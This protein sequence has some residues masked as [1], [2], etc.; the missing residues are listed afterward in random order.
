MKQNL[1]I[2]ANRAAAR[3]EPQ[4]PS[5]RNFLIIAPAPV[6]DAS[7]YEEQV[8]A[9]AQ[10]LSQDGYTYVARS[11]QKQMED[12]PFGVRYLPLHED[13]P[14]FGHMTAVVVAGDPVWAERAAA[15]YRGADVFLLQPAPSAHVSV[16]KSPAR[17]KNPLVLPVGEA[18]Q[19]AA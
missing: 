19:G 13:L 16:P 11:D 5:Y 17:R 4:S 12:T 18:W 8:V 9:L 1:Q 6:G 15:A 2:F 7:G 3:A 14:C 10:D